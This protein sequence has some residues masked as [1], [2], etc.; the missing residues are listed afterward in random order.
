MLKLAKAEFIIMKSVF[1]PDKP[2]GIPHQN[3]G[4]LLG[5]LIGL[6]FLTFIEGG[7]VHVLL[8][9]KFQAHLLAWVLT[10]ISIY[11]FLWM[12]GHYQLLKTRGVEFRE[13]GL[14]VPYGMTYQVCIPYGQ[15]EDIQVTS[16][17]KPEPQVLA[18]CIGGFSN[19]TLKLKTPVQAEVLFGV[20]K[21]SSTTV[22]LY[23]PEP[24]K[25]RA[26]LQVR[27]QE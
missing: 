9:A 14:Y 23:L 24:S 3:L 17:S 21:R 19:L 10:G 5:M 22:A 16:P 12:I 18:C 25:I 4:T 2:S 7:L 20:M 13:D 27:L 15:I 11:S 1:R 6:G 26:E 8:V